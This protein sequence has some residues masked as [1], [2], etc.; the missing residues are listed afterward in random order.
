MMLCVL[1]E[2]ESINLICWVIWKV[3]KKCLRYAR[4]ASTNY[5]ILEAKFEAV[6]ASYGS[7]LEE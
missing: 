4:P 5:D 3:G 1:V 7:A 2:E 6:L